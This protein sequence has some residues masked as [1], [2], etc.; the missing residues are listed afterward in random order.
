[1]KRIMLGTIVMLTTP[2]IV[3]CVLLFFGINIFYSIDFWCAYMAY[4]ATII[5][6]C[7]AVYQNKK[8]QEVNER[9]AKENNQMQKIQIQKSIPILNVRFFSTETTECLPAFPDNLIDDNSLAIKETVSPDNRDT[10]IEVHIGSQRK[11]GYFVKKVNLKLENISESI[12]RQ[13]SVNKIEFSGFSIGGETVRLTE[14]NGNSK[15]K[16]ISDLIF[17]NNSI[18]ISINIY[19]SDIRYKKFWE[20]YDLNERLIGEFDICLY[21]TNTTI[22]NVSYQEKIYIKK[23]PNF[24]EKIMYKIEEDHPNA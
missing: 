6:S 5:L 14:C 10:Q 12:F 24:K 11:E 16:F 19:F 15:Y 18:D 21:L 3:I 13:I 23:A 2:F 17:P 4:I 9:L 8:A 22:S 20:K 7:I 1:M